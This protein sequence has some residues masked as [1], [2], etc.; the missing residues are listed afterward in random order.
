MPNTPTMSRPACR[1]SSPP[2]LAA[3]LRSL[4]ADDRGS[5]SVMSVFFLLA[6]VVFANLLMNI[7]VSTSIKVEAQN[8]ADAVAYSAA[9][10][11][12]RALNSITAANHIS[13]EIHALELL[14]FALGGYEL[15]NQTDPEQGA[16]QRRRRERRENKAW[17]DGT[18]QAA[19]AAGGAPPVTLFGNE[20]KKS[21][22]KTSDVGGMIHDTRM[23]LG[24]NAAIA[25]ASHAVGGA[26]QQSRFPPVVAIGVIVSTAASAAEGILLAQAKY[27]EF[28][29]L[30]ARTA[31]P[32][33]TASRLSL[34]NLQT[35][36]REARLN[37]IRRTNA[38]TDR[39]ARTGVWHTAMYDGPPTKLLMVPVEAEP[40][41]IA[42]ERS[43][44][45]RAAWPHV[46]YGR[47]RLV[48]V[49]RIAFLLTGAAGYYEGYTDSY[50]PEQTTRQR[51][52][53]GPLNLMIL[54]DREGAE[55]GGRERW[56]RSD[57]S[58]RADELF[59]FM[60][61]ARRGA[62]TY[63]RNYQTDPRENGIAAYAQALTYSANPQNPGS[64][65]S[66]QQELGW[67]TLNWA[68]TV[69]E[70]E[71]DS[72][73]EPLIALGWDAKLVPVTR[74][75]EL[76]LALDPRWPGQVVRTLLPIEDLTGMH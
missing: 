26:L 31:V 63:G 21:V 42:I 57:G 36:A 24:R 8:A 32:L 61:L 12:A 64:D 28:I 5:Y 9:L 66:W 55:G 58:Q 27:L 59:A 33:K 11:N 45:M 29:E 37:A 7:G 13:G 52:R 6:F 65:R 2:G 76:G 17:V 35:Y 1:R 40:R 68:S 43:Q 75:H 4:A 19:R 16:T 30:T 71:Q 62:P 72:T 34:A 50:T 25:F 70:Y 15:E 23:D 10:E 69:P 48:D 49:F 3:R 20:L 56:T 54:K 22:T 51:R 44:L 67:N 74:I 18:Y 60:G 46:T 38:T 39:I 14:H 41:E 53:L 47:K 73:A